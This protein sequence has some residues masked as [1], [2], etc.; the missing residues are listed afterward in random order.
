MWG[1]ERRSRVQVC[2]TQ[3]NANLPAQE[4]WVVG[5]LLE[6][7]CRRTEQ[8]GIERLRLLSGDST[9]RRWQGEGHQEVGNRQQQGVLLGEPFLGGLVLTGRAMAVTTGVVAIAGELAGR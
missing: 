9:E 5:Q 4:A 8:Q 3:R 6:R 1:W 7:N 2:K